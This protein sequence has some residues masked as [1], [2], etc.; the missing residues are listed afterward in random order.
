MWI[1][2]SRKL[3]DVCLGHFVSS[4]EK[5]PLF[6][7]RLHEGLQILS[8]FFYADGCGLTDGKLHTDNFNKLDIEFS[9]NGV[10][11]SW[12]ILSLLVHGVGHKSFMD[13]CFYEPIKK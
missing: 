8:E 11:T 4:Q 13:R 12:T 9:L 2:S 1:N 10:S 7:D 5:S 3:R 6:F